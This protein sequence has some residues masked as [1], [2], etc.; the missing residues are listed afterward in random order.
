MLYLS[1]YFAVH[2][3]GLSKDLNSLPSSVIALKNSS[4]STAAFKSFPSSLSTSSPLTA[5]TFL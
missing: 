3:S 2:Q 1:P 4:D 5:I